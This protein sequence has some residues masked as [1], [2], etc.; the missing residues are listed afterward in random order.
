MDVATISLQDAGIRKAAILVAS[1]DQ[2]AAD[3]LL[4]QLGPERADLVRQAVAYLDEIDAEERQRIID[5][6]RR[7]GPMVPGP[8]PSGIELDRLP[9][10]IGGADILV[11]QVRRDRQ[12]CLPSW[13]RR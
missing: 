11:C 8:S 4:R 6:F 7:I 12:K 2:A 9:A 1:L 5:E 13:R 3:V 10:P